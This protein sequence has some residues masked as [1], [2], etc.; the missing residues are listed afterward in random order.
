[1]DTSIPFKPDSKN[2]SPYAQG[3]FV[4]RNVVYADVKGIKVPQIAGNYISVV[5]DRTGKIVLG[6]KV[7][8]TMDAITKDK[9]FLKIS[10]IGINT[11]MTFLDGMWTVNSNKTKI[12]VNPDGT[13]YISS[14]LGATFYIPR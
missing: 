6:K 3:D 9:G 5:F 10:A 14:E 13:L 7:F 2:A 4:T 1:M 11:P 8:I 12:T